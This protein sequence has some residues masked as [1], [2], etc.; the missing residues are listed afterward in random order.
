MKWI[1]ARPF[2]SKDLQQGALEKSLVMEQLVDDLEDEVLSAFQN[3]ECS[4][5]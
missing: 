5:S 1:K 2:I 3:L 4:N